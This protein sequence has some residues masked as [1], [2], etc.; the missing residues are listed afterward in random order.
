MIKKRKVKELFGEALL[1]LLKTSKI[2]KI[3]VKQ[4]AD[5][6]GLSTKTFYNHFTDKYQLMLWI[7]TNLKSKI[8][9]RAEKSGFSFHEYILG[10]IEGTDQLRDYL[11]NG[12]SAVQDQEIFYTLRVNEIYKEALAYLLTKN[13]IDSLPEEVLFELRFHIYG[14]VGILLDYSK[15]P[16]MTADDLAD[17]IER[18]LS[19]GIKPY[20]L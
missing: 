17:M 6:S 8:H 13:H 15:K 16:E 9:D 10:V 18:C 14:V 12:V 19:D 1:E 3:T 5:A 11:R 4:I 20:Y 7:E 2:E